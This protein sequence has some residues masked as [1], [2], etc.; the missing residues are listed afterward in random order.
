[1]IIEAIFIII[2]TIIKAII[3]SNHNHH[4]GVHEVLLHV[5]EGV[6]RVAKVLLHLWYEDD[7][8]EEEDDDDVDDDAHEDDV[9]DVDDD[10]DDDDDDDKNES[11]L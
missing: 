3:K 1:M 10:V 2:I 6:Q 5:I 11:A 9:D 7:D 4:L 8:D